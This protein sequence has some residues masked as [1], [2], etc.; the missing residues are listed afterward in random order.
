MA[1]IAAT[2]RSVAVACA[3]VLA[4]AM[5]SWVLVGCGSVDTAKAVRNATWHPR[6]G[7]HATGF[8][9]SADT[10]DVTF[11]GRD[12]RPMPTDKPGP[13]VPT[14]TYVVK[15]SGRWPAGTSTTSLLKPQQ[16]GGVVTLKPICTRR[17]LCVHRLRIRREWGPGPGPEVRIVTDTGSIKLRGPAR[18][19]AQSDTGS[20]TITELARVADIRATTDTGN[21]DIV[22]GGPVDLQADSDSGRVKIG[23]RVIARASDR[24]PGTVMATTD[25][26]DVTLTR[27][28]SR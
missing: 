16:T 5:A 3:I 25:T 4:T 11:D 2:S 23:D 27:R 15:I 1:Y 12:D 17:S 28:P 14:A 9:V 6:N 24:R 19:V 26:G 18:M 7:G 22:V 10:T 13:T 20:I 21:I 8:I